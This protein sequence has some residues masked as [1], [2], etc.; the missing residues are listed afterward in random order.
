[1]TA[2]I[3]VASGGSY[4]DLPCPAYMGY[5]SVP[6]EVVI[7]GTNTAGVLYKDRVRIRHSIS[8]TWNAVTPDEKNTILSLTSGNSFQ[9]R[10]FDC[11]TS[12][13]RY[14]KFYRGNDLAITPLLTYDGVEFGA[15]NI[16]MSMVEF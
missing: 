2:I 13:F 10:H 14:G 5:S 7:S 8:L 4:V 15:Y 3:A 6:N 9:V 16:T 12:E 11:S 1:M